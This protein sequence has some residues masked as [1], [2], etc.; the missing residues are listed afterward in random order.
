MH[1]DMSYNKILEN[2]EK[3]WSLLNL[4]NY[5]G[6]I[7]LLAGDSKGGISLWNVEKEVR[8]RQYKEHESIVYDMKPIDGYKGLVSQKGKMFI[9]CSKDGT[10][11]LW[12]VER[13]NSVKTF[14]NKS[15]V[16]CIDNL[17]AF[18]TQYFASGDKNGSL[19]IWNLNSTKEDTNLINEIVTCL[20]EVWRI[21]HLRKVKPYNLILAAGDSFIKLYDLNDYKCINTFS[22]HTDRI[23]SLTY[24]KNKRFGSTSADNTIKI[25]SLEDFTCHRTIQV[26]NEVVYSMLHLNDYVDFNN[27]EDDV[28]ISGGA[29]KKVNYYDYLDQRKNEDEDN[30]ILTFNTKEGIYKM[31]YMPNCKKTKIA[32]IDYGCDKD[33][34]LWGSNQ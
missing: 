21:L 17:E 23:H 8:F 27:I 6:G 4:P 26:H 14:D 7:T 3:L 25:W 10:V 16:Y 32:S 20:T 13:T 1:S 22:Q 34:Y 29:D 18:N 12:N 19:K 28:I 24:L 9:T 30:I 33:M 15:T 5:S 2:D 11:K 31:V